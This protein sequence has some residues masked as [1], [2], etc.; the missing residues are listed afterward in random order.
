[1]HA[2]MHAYILSLIILQLNSDSTNVTNNNDT[3]DNDTIRLL[4]ILI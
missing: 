3:N 1:M 2:C 4:I